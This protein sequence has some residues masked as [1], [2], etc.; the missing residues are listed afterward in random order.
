MYYGWSITVWVIYSCFL[1]ALFLI[2]VIKM[3]KH[4]CCSSR[5]FTFFLFCVLGVVNR[6]EVGE[7]K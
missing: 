6:L 4:S 5:S 2:A 3:P 1:A 7:E